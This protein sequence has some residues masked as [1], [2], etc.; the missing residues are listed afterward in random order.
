MSEFPVFAR[1]TTADHRL[2]P[3]ETPDDQLIEQMP[4]EYFVSAYRRTFQPA[5]SGAIED[6]DRI[7]RRCGYRSSRYWQIWRSAS[8][9]ASPINTDAPQGLSAESDRHP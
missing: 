8:T 9:T 4:D 6:I 7:Y 2:T 3:D 1:S 5:R